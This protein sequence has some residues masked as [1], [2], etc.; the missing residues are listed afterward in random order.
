M[1]RF[2][3]SFRLCLAALLCVGLGMSLSGCKAKYPNC[4]GDSDCPGNAQGKEWCVNNQCQ[5]CRPGMSD[6]GAGRT[7]NLGRCEAI[8][9][10]C[11][12]GKDCPSGVCQNHICA[13]CKDDSG[14]PGGGRCTAGRCVA[15]ER[16]KC[17]NS[18]ECAETEDCV[19]GRCVPANR[20]AADGNGACTPE[21]VF[22]GSNEFELGAGSSPVVDKDAECLKKLNRGATLYGHTDPRGTL[23]YNLALSEKRAQ[24]V[25]RRMTDLGISDQNLYT[26]PRGE[27]DATGTD[28]AS[29]ERDR[30]VEV[31]PR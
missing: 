21:T 2:R 31:K 5:Q 18:D 17:K 16:K 4:E 15:D 3:S 10:Y 22:F 11:N 27:L 28:D 23:E 14:C 19:Q 30:R 25:K 6:C 9:G 26:V 1:Q 7:C 12:T 20:Y 24:A 29:Y 8:R 13:A